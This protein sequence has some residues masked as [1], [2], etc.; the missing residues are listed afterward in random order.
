MA[1]AVILILWCP[2]EE[3]PDPLPGI[4]DAPVLP[5]P[6]EHAERT[7]LAASAALAQRREKRTFELLQ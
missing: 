1:I 6:P 3:T 5:V 4:A 2:I 7:R